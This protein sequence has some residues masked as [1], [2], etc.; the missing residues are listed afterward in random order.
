MVVPKAIRDAHGWAPGTRL[1]AEATPEGM[2]VR[3]DASR[4]L[5]P[6][7]RIEDVAGCLHRPGRAALSIE[8]MD[9]AVARAAA[10]RLAR[11]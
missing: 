5:V 1:V 6:P 8:E 4:P 3:R 7:T 11:D 2:L 10:S 9:A